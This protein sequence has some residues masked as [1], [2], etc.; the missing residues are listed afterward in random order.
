MFLHCKSCLEPR[1]VWDKVC[2]KC[3]VVLPPVEPC[4]FCKGKGYI[5]EGDGPVDCAVCDGMGCSTP[6]A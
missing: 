1:D 4:L 6:S 3:G 2:G 5:D